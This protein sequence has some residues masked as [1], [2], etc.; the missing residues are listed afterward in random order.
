MTDS[1][2]IYKIGI[3]LI[4][5]IG[6]IH[7][8][9]LIAYVGSIEGVFKE[10]KSR[11]KSIPGIGETLADY[12]KNQNVLDKAKSETEYMK[13]NGIKALFFSDTEYPERLKHCNDAPMMLYVKGDIDFNKPKYISVVGTRN[14]TEEGKNNCIKLIQGFIEKKHYPVIVSGLA[15]GIDICAHR[16]ALDNELKTI[17]VFAHGLDR[18]Y[19]YLHQQIAEKIKHQ[20][21]L[22]TEFCSGTKIDRNFFLRRNRIIAGL[23][24]ATIV[25]ESGIKGGA[26]VTADI[27]HSYNRDVLTYPG[28]VSDVYSAGCN[29]LIKSNKAALILEADDVEKILNWD[30]DKT[31]KK[32]LQKILFTDL[33]NEEETIV[34]FLKQSGQQSV[35]TISLNIK[36][37]VSKVSSH[38]LNLEFTGLVKS[39]PGK[40]YSLIS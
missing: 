4:P 17:A 28:R 40:I 2:L 12:I 31:R 35:D 1:L 20:G 14:S 21:A 13:K 33:S 10:K 8:K 9:N 30:V 18:V 39:H 25:V 36:M 38:L 16:A 34:D 22:V 29:M 6:V 5:K 27:A 7:A 24:D 19:P 3:S 26:L 23:S 15:Y 11:L 32:P 37:P